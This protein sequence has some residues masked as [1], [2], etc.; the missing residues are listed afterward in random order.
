MI[1]TRCAIPIDTSETKVKWKAPDSWGMINGHTIE[2][3]KYD[4][5]LVSESDT[6]N[7]GIIEAD[8]LNLYLNRIV[9]SLELRSF[10]GKLY[11][12]WISS[13]S[14]AVPFKVKRYILQT[15]KK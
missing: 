5:R 7:L 14:A 15:E 13:D 1:F 8:S 10:N 2:S 11:S 9:Y 12:E 3:G 4:V 6:L